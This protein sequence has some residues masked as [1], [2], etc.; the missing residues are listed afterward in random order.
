[1]KVALILD[2]FDPARGGLERYAAD[3]AGW[4]LR[5]G[6]DVHVVAG[7]GN[8]ATGEAIILHRIDG[9][10]LDAFG[11]AE[12]LAAQAEALAPDAVHDF[13]AGLGGDIFH[14]LGGARGAGRAGE[15]RA[16]GFARRWRRR[17]SPGWRRKQVRFDALAREQLKDPNRLVV[18]CSDRVSRDLLQLAGHSRLN[19]RVVY[20]AVDCRRFTPYPPAER[21]AIRKSEG[22]P[23]SGTL[24]L[25]VAHN[26]RLKGVAQ[27]LKAMARL[28]IQGFDIHLAVAGRGPNLDHYQGLAGRLGILARVRF[29]GPVEDVRRLYAAA[30]ALVHP[31]FYDSC[32]LA[33]L[34]AWASG[35]PIA[36]S[37]EDG[38]SGLLTEGVQG[39]LIRDPGDP[40]EI[41]FQMKQLLDPGQREAMGAQG[42]VLAEHN[43]AEDA[44]FRL[45]ALCCEA[46]Q[47]RLA[48]MRGNV[49]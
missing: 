26:F 42:R 3:W 6:H 7:D 49:A 31:A 27:A 19:L 25:Q 12:Q 13:G 20:N 8:V 23:P 40:A 36:V 17:M 16:L 21:A 11:Q 29:L 30:D 34:E 1:M 45:E 44:F 48:R 41:A 9:S 18:A 5:R 38:V 35:L 46:A 47:M 37:A 22:W 39:C 2:H 15:L 10:N 32:S 33:C 14:P 43:G 4:L 28:V 24:F